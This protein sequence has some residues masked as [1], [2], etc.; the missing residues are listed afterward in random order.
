MRPQVVDKMIMK[1][2]CQTHLVHMSLTMGVNR[3]SLHWVTLLI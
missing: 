1:I 2:L 3:D